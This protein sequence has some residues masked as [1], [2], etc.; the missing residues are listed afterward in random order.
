MTDL[1]QLTMMQG[2]FK[3]GMHKR[4]AFFDLFFRTQDQINYAIMAGLEQVVDYIKNLKFSDSDIDYLKSLNL[5]DT[6]FLKYL[7]D[8][9]F[10]GDIFSVEEGE[11]V[12]PNEPILI[13]K[14]PMGQAQLIETTLLNIINHQTLIASKAARIVEA[15][16]EAQVIEF[17]LRRAQGPDAGI[18]GTR[19]AMI[20]GCNG[21]SNVM[22]AK[23]FNI[24]AK[25]THGHSFVQSFNSE[26]EAFRAFSKVYPDSCLLL[27]DTYDTLKSGVPNAI[28]IFNELKQAGHK[29]LGIRLDSG[30][31]AY[32]SKAA[33]VMLDKAGFSDT[34]IFASNDIDE[35]LIEQLKLQGA[36]IDVYGVG[37][38][39]ITSADMP[40]LGG[41]Y[42][43]AA[44]EEENGNIKSVMKFSDSEF[45]MTNPAFKNLYRIYS[46]DSGM[47][48]ADL[49]TLNGEELDNPLTLTHP[50]ERYREV[51]LTDY[52]ARPMLKQIFYGGKLVYK[53]PTLKATIEFSRKEKQKFWAEH[54]RITRPQI[55]KVN[56]SNGLYKLKQAIILSATPKVSQ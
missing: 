5:F 17:G 46:G 9:K 25:G 11:V 23:L 34:V 47:A 50:T 21:T 33:R 3:N 28:K 38:K 24:L 19:A 16:G 27:V 26:S 35:H 30:D 15:A 41:V 39:L 22:S 1:Y 53:I 49:I 36:K 10:T 45:K 18:Y 40:S 32:L 20:G 44:L 14:A 13:V 4:I 12:F 2:F 6:D 31:L 42:K 7:K 43:L 48:Y 52:T 37:T 51:T 54:K 8:F 56:L 29:P 55:Y